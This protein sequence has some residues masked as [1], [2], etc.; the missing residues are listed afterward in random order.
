MTKKII[1][2]LMQQALGCKVVWTKRE[3][4]L[5]PTYHSKL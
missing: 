5:L 4:A 3:A 2:K 1:L